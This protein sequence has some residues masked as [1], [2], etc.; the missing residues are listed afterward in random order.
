M[1][2]KKW[3][4]NEE[5]RKLIVLTEQFPY[6]NAESFLENEVNYWNEF[7]EVIIIPCTAKDYGRKRNVPADATVIHLQCTNKSKFHKLFD[8]LVKIGSK[9]VRNELKALIKN[10]NLSVETLKNLL[11]F[12]TTADAVQREVYD[13]VCLGLHQEDTHIFY[14]Y[15]MDFHAYVLCRLKERLADNSNNRFV[16]RC[17]GYDLYE[18][19]RAGNYIPFR[20]EVL[21]GLDRILAISHDGKRYLSERYPQAAAKI[22]VSALGTKDGGLQPQCGRASRLTLVSCARVSRVK[23]MERIVEALAQIETPVKWVHLGDGI[24]FDYIQRLAE[25]KLKDNSMVKYEF[26]GGMDNSQIME[27]YQNEQCDVFV[28]VSESEGVPVSI[29]EAI[30]FGIPVI[31]TNVGGVS[32]I[33]EQGYNGI[34]IESTDETPMLLKETIERI[35]DMSEQEYM[36]LRQNARTKWERDFSA[37][38]NYRKFIGQISNL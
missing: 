20:N 10:R 17:H 19:R 38:I 15:W 4:L 37:D 33:V 25:E 36:A 18:E 12:C 32:E 7:D 14:S 9:P 22:E 3:S 11:F 13:K 29:M 34:L 6:G 24:L 27:Y 31:A 28:N 30:S 8:Y 23:R 1:L 16:S 35:A 5:M 2:N 21:S 26:A